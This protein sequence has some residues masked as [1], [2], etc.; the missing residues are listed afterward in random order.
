MCHLLIVTPCVYCSAWQSSSF[1]IHSTAA[2]LLKA[3]CICREAPNLRSW[4]I[5]DEQ[6]RSPRICE[7]SPYD[8]LTCIAAFMSPH[9]LVC[10]LE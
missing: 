1:S 2:H 3:P 8:A 7:P 6:V 9:V 4:C 5:S 10:A